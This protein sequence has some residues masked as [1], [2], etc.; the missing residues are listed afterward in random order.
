MSDHEYWM[1]GQDKTAQWPTTP[2][3]GQGSSE[4]ESTDP[5]GVASSTQEGAP[6][7]PLPAGA[8]ASTAGPRT[9]GLARSQRL[10]QRH[11]A[12][13]A[14]PTPLGPGNGGGRG[15]PGPR[16]TTF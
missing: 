3:N 1:S 5:L 13:A 10:G 7:W 12:N 4:A 14:G 8:T 15:R 11:W 16:P 9:P 2:P 6:T